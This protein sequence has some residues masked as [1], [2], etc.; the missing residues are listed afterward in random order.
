MSFVFFLVFAFA[1]IAI[2]GD[3]YT[4]QRGLEAGMTEMNPLNRWLFKKIGLPFT[5]WLEGIA[6]V[7]TALAFVS[8]SENAATAYC[9]IVGAW[10][11]YMYFRNKGIL[12][13]AKVK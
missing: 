1:A 11:A 8:Y 7:G 9:T 6:F 3:F 2:L 4:T 5:A 13:K 12:N 10:E